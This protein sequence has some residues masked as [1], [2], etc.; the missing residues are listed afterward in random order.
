MHEHLDCPFCT[1]DSL[2]PFITSKTNLIC[3]DFHAEAT[4]EKEAMGYYLDGKVSS[5]HGTHT[6]VQTA[7]ER[8][9]PNGTAYISDLGYAGALNS[10]LGMRKDEITLRFI[11]QMPHRFVVE[12]E[13][14]FVMFGTCVEIDVKTGKAIS[15]ERLKVVD[16]ELSV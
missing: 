11:T 12:T 5:V 8:V 13:G 7:D 4:S 6:H 2:L 3:V 10:M 9:L 15:I 1:I 16:E 14:P